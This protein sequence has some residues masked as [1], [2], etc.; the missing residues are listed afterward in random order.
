MNT[1]AN[2]TTVDKPLRVYSGELTV[3]IFE[4]CKWSVRLYSDKA[5][6]RVPYVKWENNSGT[7]DFLK[8]RISSGFRLDELR[9]LL[10]D[11]LKG[12]TLDGYGCELD[13]DKEA[14]WIVEGKG[15]TCPSRHKSNAEVV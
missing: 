3:G 13:F 15:A 12:K 9:C 10:D 1:T 2:A 6:C 4:R 7:L 5:I 8:E 11:E 14:L